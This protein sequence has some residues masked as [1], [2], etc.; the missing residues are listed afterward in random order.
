MLTILASSSRSRLIERAELFQR[1]ATRG[2]LKRL[3]SVETLA[4]KLKRVVCSL[5]ACAALTAIPQ[6]A[7]ARIFPMIFVTGASTRVANAASPFGGNGAIEESIK[8]GQPQLLIQ[9]LAMP[10]DIAVSDDV[11]YVVIAGK[12]MVSAFSASDGHLINDNVAPAPK[13]PLVGIAAFGGN[14]FVADSRTN[15]INEYNSSG[16]LVAPPFSQGIRHPTEITASGGN[17]FVVNQG[18]G[19]LAEYITEYDAASGQKLD[20]NLLQGLHGPIQITVLGNDLF[21]TN[22]ST[23]TI[24]K[25]DLTTRQ[26][27]K[28]FIPSLNGPTDIASFDPDPSDADPGELFVTDVP[29]KSIDVYDAATGNLARTIPGLHG[30]P[31]G[32]DVV[33]GNTVPDQS[34][35]WMLLLL[36]ITAIF[37]FKLMLRQLA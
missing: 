1:K 8:F 3:S 17:L 28:G 37:S 32:I 2:P 27:T 30:R 24:D 33:P 25:L 21:V 14:V 7:C 19:K 23:H 4:M 29:N 16:A 31:Q 20:G 5:A 36:G 15:T 11:I 34:A 26:L 10:T 12:G 6:T 35:T 18:T 9:N 22:I 13:G